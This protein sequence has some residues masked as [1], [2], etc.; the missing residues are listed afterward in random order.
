MNLYDVL[1]K[2]VTITSSGTTG[3]PKTIFRTPE[4]L[5]ACNE[6]ALKAQDIDKSSKILT[7]T[8]MTHAGGLL[9][10]T[11]PAYSI[12][13][14]YTI[15]TFNPY[16]FLSQF[17][18]HTHTFLPPRMIDALLQTKNFDEA[19]FTEKFVAMGS[20]PIPSHHV[21]AFTERGATVLCNWGMSEIGP[22]TINKRF[23]PYEVCHSENI[24]GDTFWTD[25]K[26]ESGI[27]WVK[28]PMC[29]YEDWFCTRDK[30]KT[31][32]DTLFYEGRI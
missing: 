31:V 19:D 29:V 18:E 10:Q 8:R 13:A 30:V 25:Y 3:D 27:L 14:E 28:G 23:E 4:N 15:T 24:L 9:L 6:V 5:L 2:G 17:K 11:L 12:G 16:S 32:G 7:V 20:D 26:I 22:C 21:N 1:N